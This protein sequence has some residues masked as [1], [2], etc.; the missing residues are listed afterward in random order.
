M[1]TRPAAKRTR[2][3]LM[4]PG[5]RG[6]AAVHSLTNDHFQLLVD[7]R[8]LLVRI[9]LDVVRRVEWY[10]RRHAGAAG[11]P[12]RRDHGAR[13]KKDPKKKKIRMRVSALR[14]HVFDEVIYLRM[15][16]GMSMGRG[17]EHSLGRRHRC[18][19]RGYG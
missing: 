18:Y 19:L 14:R 16:T 4:T 7:A 2:A 12:R 3:Q 15:G 10:I 6:S 1:A 17:P 11:R 9:V 13:R 8:G 5:M